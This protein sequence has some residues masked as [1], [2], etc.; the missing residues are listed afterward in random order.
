MNLH[1]DFT[2]RCLYKSLEFIENINIESEKFY[3]PIINQK[4]ITFFNLKNY[5]AIESITNKCVCALENNDTI[6]SDCSAIKFLKS[7]SKLIT[8]KII[9]VNKDVKC[10]RSDD[11]PFLMY[12]NSHHTQKNA[13]IDCLLRALELNNY[14]FDAFEEL[15]R[16]VDLDNFYYIQEKLECVITNDIVKYIYFLYIAV[17]KFIKFDNLDLY[18]SGVEQHFNNISSYENLLHTKQTNETYNK[19]EN[20]AC[21]NPKNNYIIG[22]LG[23]VHYFKKD[24]DVSLSY[25]SLL[26]SKNLCFMD[27]YSNLLYI[28]NDIKKLAL[29]SRNL[30]LHHPFAGETYTAIGN[31]YSLKKEREK[32]IENFRK[33]IEADE[34][35]TCNYTL[36][37]HEYME[38]DNQT[39]AISSYNKAL[40]YC[41]SDHRALFGMGQALK[42]IGSAKQAL[43]FYQK[44]CELQCNEPYFWMNF[45]ATAAENNK[46]D[47]AIQAYQRSIDLGETEAFLKLGDCY[48][49]MKK[50]SEAVEVYEKYVDS[51]IQNEIEC[52]KICKFL[53]EFYKRV[54]NKEKYDFYAKVALYE[55]KKNI[56]FL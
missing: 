53:T 46:Y 16:F 51:C 27:F 17:Y 32:A 48:K 39:E 45:G 20:T 41:K 18:I 40:K 29:L 24:Y 26:N 30:F 11:D 2:K 12:I 13:S 38:L 21:N 15:L 47:V 56:K 23:A 5:S 42:S 52:K 49:N 19:N 7:Y 54:G 34:K 33:S 43:Y 35:F 14:F 3:M 1:E 6:C 55:T 10:I 28:K 44:V 31:Y 8:N 22:L 9:N 36:I 4:A 25:F 50:Y 37:G